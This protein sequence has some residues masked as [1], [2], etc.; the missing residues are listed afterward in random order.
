M[1]LNQLDFPFGIFVDNNES[2]YAGDF[3]NHRI[4]KWN[5]GASEGQIVAGGNRG[6]SR[7][8]QLN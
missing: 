1:D 6:G 3:V 7:S 8:D 4:V 5:R 2:I